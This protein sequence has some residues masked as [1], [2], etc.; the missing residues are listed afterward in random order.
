MDWQTRLDIFLSEFEHKAD[1]V[2]VLVCGSYITG[3]PSNHSDLDVHVVLDDDVCYRERGNRI[4]DGLLIEYFANPPHQI[5]KY[6]DEDFADKSL[7]SQVQFATGKIVM[8]E[9]GSCVFEEKSGC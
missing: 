5:L 6:F 7:M 9:K 2:G 4:I 3:S 8:D 1:V